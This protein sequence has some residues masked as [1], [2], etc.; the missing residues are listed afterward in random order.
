MR[1]A[2][3]WRRQGRRRRSGRGRLRP[4]RTRRQRHPPNSALPE[5]TSSPGTPGPRGPVGHPRRWRPGSRRREAPPAGQCPPREA[6]GR[7][8]RHCVRPGQPRP[9][10]SP[11]APAPACTHRFARGFVQAGGVRGPCPDGAAV[12]EERVVAQGWQRRV[13]ARRQ[14]HLGHWAGE[15]HGRPHGPCAHGLLVVQ[16]FARLRGMNEK[17]TRESELGPRRSALFSVCVRGASGVCACL[18]NLR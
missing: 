6:R 7:A 8:H 10:L 3:R 13:R 9:P 5:A 16:L 15:S 4:K 12:S 2:R 1:A 17:R 11:R 18:C 14:R